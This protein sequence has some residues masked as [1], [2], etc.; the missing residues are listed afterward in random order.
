MKYFLSIIFAALLFVSCD[1]EPVPMLPKVVPPADRVVLIE[2]FTGVSCANCPRGARL[3]ENLKAQYPG[4][5]VSLAVYTNGFDNRAPE[6]KYDFKTAAGQEL[7]DNIS[8]L[9]GKPAAAIN[10]VE[11]ASSGSRFLYVADTWTPAVLQELQRNV[12]MNMTMTTSYNAATRTVSGTITMIPTQ[13][14]NEQVSYTIVIAE[15]KIIDPQDDDGVIVLDYEHN[16]V[17]RDALTAPTGDVLGS[18]FATGEVVTRNFSYTLPAEDGWWVADNCEII[19]F[20][21]LSE[22]DERRVLQAVKADVVN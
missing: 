2:D 22:G 9:F 6:S 15:N 10:R 13:D 14:F 20:A 11:D 12:E 4:S 21:H 16:H 19:A 8:P 17:F 1:E 7:Q 5:I 3:I 18:S